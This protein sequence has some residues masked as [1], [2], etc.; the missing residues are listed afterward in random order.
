MRNL[1]VN[2]SGFALCIGHEMKLDEQL[3]YFTG[4]TRQDVRA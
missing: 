1:M 2:S 3:R 4:S